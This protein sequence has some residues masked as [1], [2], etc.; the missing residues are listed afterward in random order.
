M[1]KTN[2][3]KLI[4]WLSI[5]FGIGFTFLFSNQ[6]SANA[7]SFE[8]NYV[9]YL[10]NKKWDN[11][12][13]NETLWDLSKVGIDKDKSIIENIKNIFYPDISGQWWRLWDIIKVLWLV[14]FVL[15]LVWQWFQYALDSD[16]E[17][18]VAKYHLNFA[19]IFLG[20]IIFF[21][22][23]WILWIWLWFA[24]TGDGWSTELINNIDRN[25]MFQVFTWLRAGA[26]FLA[27][28]LLWYTWRS[29]MAA[30]D[31]EGKVKAWRQGILNIVVSLIII[32]VIDYMYYIA[33]TPSFKSKITEF[34]VEASKALWYVLWS[35]FTI[36]LIYYWFRLMFS[37]GSD[38]SL[39]KVKDI[40][41]GVFLWSLVIFIFFLIVYQIAQ[42][43]SG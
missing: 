7:P 12:N 36:M 9:D 15:M 24:G 8:D 29:M 1:L 41:I 10:T 11:P 16:D 6:A 33:Q 30:M 22:A 38:E 43:F 23:T 31:D 21:G 5:L 28:V 19:Y 14:V 3:K 32:K 4:F 18:K 40:I 25:I 17:S 27:I 26:F 37:N 35:F 39:Q 20:A 2:I 42:E 13:W 34:I